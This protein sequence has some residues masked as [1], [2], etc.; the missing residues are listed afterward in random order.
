M[1]DTQPVVVYH[2]V[3]GSISVVLAVPGSVSV[4][5]AVPGSVSMVLVVPWSVSAVI[6]VPRSVFVVLAVPGS[7]SV[8]LA[9]PGSVSV[10]LPPHL[11]S[12]GRHMTSGCLP[13]SSWVCL[14]YHPTYTAMGDTQ[15]VVVYLAVPGSVSVVLA[16]PGS[17]SEVL[18][19]HLHSNGRHTASGCL[20]CSSWVCL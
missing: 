4:V 13:H 16:V 2:A 3:P 7:V 19:P 1:G 11:H 10:M 15:P 6:A 14:C 18:P 20:P 17:V 8:V 5:L 9:V 12:T